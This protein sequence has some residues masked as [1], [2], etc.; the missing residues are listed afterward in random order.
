MAIWM[1]EMGM[2]QTIMARLLW[3]VACKESRS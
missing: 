2:D 3:E 1:D